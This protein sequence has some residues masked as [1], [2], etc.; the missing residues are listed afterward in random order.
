MKVKKI[1]GK[2]SVI[3]AIEEMEE[4]S[5]VAYYSE[6][7]LTFSCSMEFAAFPYDEQLCTFKLA[8]YDVLP[9]E[10][11]IMTTLIAEFGETFEAFSPT[12]QD[13]DYQVPLQCC[14]L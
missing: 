8:N 6:A 5:Q 10:Q 4:T 9:V 7:A 13:Y 2:P 12:D 3:L 11:F 1:F 14:N